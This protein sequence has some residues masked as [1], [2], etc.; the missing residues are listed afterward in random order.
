MN[1]KRYDIRVFILSLISLFLFTLPL[2]TSYAVWFTPG[3]VYGEFNDTTAAPDP[4]KAYENLIWIICA[5]GWVVASITFVMAF[6]TKNY[7]IKIFTLFISALII[8][9]PL[10]LLLLFLSTIKVA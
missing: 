1:N 4:L 7:F 6:W 8:V 10:F 2:T 9:M 3:F 5:A